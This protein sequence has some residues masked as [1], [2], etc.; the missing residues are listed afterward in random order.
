MYITGSHPLCLDLI[1]LFFFIGSRYVYAMRELYNK[2][3]IV[4]SFHAPHYS[5][6]WW[7]HFSHPKRKQKSIFFDKDKKFA[8]THQFMY[9][10][11]AGH[12]V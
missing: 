7:T 1:T 2:E 4:L 8:G 10:W 5:I 3:D 11:Q 12:G 6:I 9:E